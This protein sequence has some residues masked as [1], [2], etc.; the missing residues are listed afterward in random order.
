[1][2]RISLN[3]TWSGTQTGSSAG[4]LSGVTQTLTILFVI[5]SADQKNISYQLAGHDSNGL[6]QV[7]IMLDLPNYP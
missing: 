6:S 1:M 7:Y 3:C 2:L 4:F 5:S